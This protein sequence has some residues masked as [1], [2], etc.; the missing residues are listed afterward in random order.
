MPWFFCCPKYQELRK[1]DFPIP[2]SSAMGE[3]FSLVQRGDAFWM[4]KWMQAKVLIGIHLTDGFLQLCLGKREAQL[5]GCL[6][7]AKVSGRLRTNT[8][9]HRLRDNF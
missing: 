5:S 7:M 3:I 2:D 8:R 6:A 9:K 1:V 4:D